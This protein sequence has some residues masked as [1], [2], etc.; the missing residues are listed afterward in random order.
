MVSERRNQDFQAV[1][2][3]V[4]QALDQGKTMYTTFKRSKRSNKDADE[5][6]AVMTTWVVN[7][8]TISLGTPQGTNES[9]NEWQKAKAHADLEAL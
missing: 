4:A 1:S 3:C 5:A 6:N 7:T 8:Q 9:K 2:G